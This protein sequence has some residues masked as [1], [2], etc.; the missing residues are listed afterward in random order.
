[1]LKNKTKKTLLSKKPKL[2]EN[3]LSK[4]IGLMF[5]LKPK[6]LIFKWEKEKILSLHMFFVFF[7]IDIL[8]LNKY[9]KVV[10]LKQNLK[11]FQILIPKKPAQYVIEL[12]QGTIT[13][14]KTQVN[15]LIEF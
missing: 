8:W 12:P 3:L 14:T 10:Q 2:C 5:S 1:M 13:K 4:T 9:K 7:P 6:A 15:D 11:P